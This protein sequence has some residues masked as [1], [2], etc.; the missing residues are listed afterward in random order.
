MF[1]RALL[2]V[3]VLALALGAAA[4]EAQAP[5]QAERAADM[6]ARYIISLQ[7]ADGGFPAFGEESA[8]GSTIDAI[9]ALIAAGYEP[10]PLYNKGLSPVDYLASQAA[11]YAS[12]PGAAA[13]LALA[14]ALI[15]RDPSIGLDLRD[16][17][18]VDLLDT[19]AEAVDAETGAYG[20]D[21]F[22]ECFY[23]LAL[24]AAGEPVPE[25]VLEHLRT[26]R[27]QDGGWEFSLGGGSDTN[28]T[29]MVLQALIAGGVRRG[30]HAIGAAIGYLAFS[31]NEDGGFGF[32]PGA[33]TDA[34]STALVIQALAAA[35]QDLGREGRFARASGTPVEA[36]LRFVNEET[37]ALQF[38]GADSP[39]ATYQGVPGLLLAPFP[40]LVPRPQPDLDDATAT[41][42]PVRTATTAAPDGLP[43]TGSG[44]RGGGIAWPATA[45]LGAAGVALG[46]GALAARRR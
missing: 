22:D 24:S 46:V 42:E 1:A 45:L 40:D 14:V 18:G 11:S 33:E 16:F 2:L 43:R 29:A 39:F 21:L 9:F 23:V 4:T 15:A 7:N 34:N 20:L 13:K 26:R 17:G 27:A 36:L 25:P 28:T 38:E 32:V 5:T 35:G 44:D 30:D 6:A 12:D 31:Q 10:T 19:M 37:G 3:S 41:V 8:P